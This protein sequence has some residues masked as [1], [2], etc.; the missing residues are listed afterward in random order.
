[1]SI[2]Y[3][4]RGDNFVVLHGKTEYF[5]MQNGPKEKKKQEI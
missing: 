5:R 1:M 2:G 3:P 4:V